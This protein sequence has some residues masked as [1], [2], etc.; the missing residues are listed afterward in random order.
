MI[1]TSSKPANVSSKMETP[2]WLQRA[3]KTKPKQILGG[4]YLALQGLSELYLQFVEY[5]LY[6]AKSRK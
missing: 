2:M 3:I 6:D 1:L 5:K 4:L